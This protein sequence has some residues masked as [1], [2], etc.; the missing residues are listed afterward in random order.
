[1]LGILG[2]TALLLDGGADDE[3]GKPRERA[4]LAAL[5]V[6]ANEVVP[7]EE[8]VRW[9]W[10]RDKP[11]PLHPDA[12]F[13]AYVTRIR[14]VLDRLPSPPVLS[15]ED[16]GYRLAV[17]R[18]QVDLQLFRDLIADAREAG[19]PRRA[20]DLVEGAL[21]LWR[22][23]PLAD[24]A[25][26]PARAW[27]ER[28]L[29]EE[30][31][32]AHT[33]RVQALFDLGRYDEALAA[34]DE[35]LADFPDD[36][37]L[38]TLTL[39]GLYRQHRLTD[40]T[41][42]FL[43]TWRRLRADGDE[44]AAHLLRRQYAALSAAHPAPALPRPT[45][46]PRQLPRDVRDFVGRR[47]QIAVLDAVGPYGLV[48]LDGPGGVG[49]TALAVHWA[50]RVRTRFVDGD[51]YVDM[52]GSTDQGQVGPAAV[53]DH[54]LVAL[55]QAPEPTLGRRQRERL[56]RLLVAGRRIAVVLD[57]VRDADQVRWVVELLPSCLV[58]VTSRQRLSLP[59]AYRVAVPPV[60]DETASVF[61]SM[62]ARGQVP[63]A[64]RLR[65]L[66]GGLPL[67]LTVLAGQQT[68]RSPLPLGDLVTRMDR[69]RLLA[70]V[71]ERGESAPQGE[72]CLTWAYRAL[73]PAERRLFRLLALHPGTDISAEAAHAC[74]GRTPAETMASLT[75]LV[76]AHL[77][78]PS[79]ELDRF[80]RHGV[81][82]EFA[83]RCLARDEPEDGRRAA[84][85][86]LLDFFAASATS[87]TRLLCPV[88]GAWYDDGIS[89]ADEDEAADWF[90]RERATMTALVRLAHAEGCHDRVLRLAE[91]LANLLEWSGAALESATVRRRA[92][93]SARA[94][95]ERVTEAAALH[96]LG[97]A[98]LMAE[99]HDGARQC[100]EAALDLH[101]DD[102]VLLDE[103]GQLAA[104]RGDLGEAIALYRRGIAAAERVEDA[105]GLAWLHCH[106]GQALRAA[107]QVDAALT[108]LR[109]ARMAAR[110]AGDPAAESAGLAELGAVRHDLG[111]CPGALADCADALALAEEVPDLTSAALICV[112]LAEIT[113]GCRWFDKAVEHAR[114]GVELLRGTQD[115]AT[116][117]RVVEA[118]GDAL[119]HSGEPHEAVVT[120]Q[121]AADL[122]DHAGLPGLVFR[123]RGKMDNGRIPGSAPLARAESAAPEVIPPGP[124][125]N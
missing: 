15:A 101:G 34:L 94:L 104:L 19:A 51:V 88:R 63:D 17:D 121:Q 20:L 83:A 70:V 9:V 44:Q 84:R 96:R 38:V 120:W 30:W 80:G 60:N 98:Y 43:T 16:G 116:Q 7:V 46:V 112:L 32:A 18:S 125:R 14:R 66:C 64:G 1:M 62:H 69:R 77:L 50:H 110:Q 47:E 89:F 102:V 99:N 21:W 48:V 113:T 72:S 13:D 11:V 76:A 5:L 27:R 41:R 123:L 61:L 53:V 6:H 8:L 52:G 57:D 78:D 4:V 25:T 95:G 82:A 33:I 75:H 2:T 45:L 58:L 24:L 12:T 36:L 28:V 87:A 117:A 103:L 90:R 122:Y 86:R 37:H 108:Q 115:L 55:G 91:P 49:K 40:A 74:D 79:D 10:P 22:G 81:L 85:E 71:G 111:D 29:N 118:L 59:G 124:W 39:T 73:P 42:F 23:L 65:A 109:R 31:L 67:L 97:T 107:D 3:W 54:I 56:L 114:H 106:L 100:L 26:E 68:G 119:F 92:V 35:L 105:G 93:A